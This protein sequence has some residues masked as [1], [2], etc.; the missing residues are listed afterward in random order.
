MS[1]SFWS[2]SR[3]RGKNRAGVA[4]PNSLPSLPTPAC[5]KRLRPQHC[6]LIS[7]LRIQQPSPC[8]LYSL[9]MAW[10]A[11]L[12]TYGDMSE[13]ASLMANIMMGTMIGTRMLERT[14]SALARIS[15]LGSCGGMRGAAAQHWGLAAPPDSSWVPKPAHLE[16]SLEGGDGEQGQILLLLCVAHQID[17][18]QLLHLTGEGGGATSELP[19][20]QPTPQN[21]PA[22]KASDPGDTH[23][24]HQGHPRLSSPQCSCRQR[25][26]P[27]L[28]RGQRRFYP[29]RSSRG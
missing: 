27:R 24:C 7:T 18:H 11:V 25:F 6:T 2:E 13:A 3:L 5:T 15:W 17:V 1:W 20:T 12:R 28:G 29:G 4:G 23:G 26:S 8:H 9:G 21:P 14:R 22:G 10:A 19:K 16:T